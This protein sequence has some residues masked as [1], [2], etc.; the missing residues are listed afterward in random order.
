MGTPEPDR[1][2]WASSPVCL[3]LASQNLHLESSQHRI[4]RGRQESANVH[5]KLRV[6][7][8]NAEEGPK[9]R[10]FEAKLLLR[11]T[12]TSANEK[13]MAVILEIGTV[14]IRSERSLLSSQESVRSQH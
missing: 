12:A 9:G 11:C 4:I 5:G 2:P 13:D 7:Q 6:G 8:V 14:F 10:L 3:G 1:E